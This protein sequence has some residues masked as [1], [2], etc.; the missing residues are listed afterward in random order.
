[1]GGP[2]DFCQGVG[3]GGYGRF[4]LGKIGFSQTLNEGGEVEVSFTILCYNIISVL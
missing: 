1:M 3:G 4:G 2:F